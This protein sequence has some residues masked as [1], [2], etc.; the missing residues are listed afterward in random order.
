MS[1]RKDGQVGEW[2]EVKWTDEWE[3]GRKRRWREE[4]QGWF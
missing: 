1:R 2:R 3:R 4:L